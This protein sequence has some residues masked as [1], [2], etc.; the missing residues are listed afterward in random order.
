MTAGGNGLYITTGGHGFS[1]ADRSTFDKPRR[2]SEQRDLAQ[3]AEISHQQI[4][5]ISRE[6]SN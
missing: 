3:N 5:W 4:E 1:R 2:S 6:M